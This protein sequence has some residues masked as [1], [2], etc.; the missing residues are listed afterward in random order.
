MVEFGEQIW[1]MPVKSAE[2]CLNKFE[3]RWEQGAFVGVV[4]RTGEIRVMTESGVLRTRSIRRKPATSRWDAA[5]LAKQRGL[6][7]KPNPESDET[8][9]LPAAV[10]IKVDEIKVPPVAPRTVEDMIPRRVYIRSDVELARY[11]H[12]PKCPGCGAALQGAQPRT[13]SEECRA[14][15]ESAMRADPEQATRTDAADARLVEGMREKPG[16]LKSGVPPKRKAETQDPAPDGKG[17][18]VVARPEGPRTGS[19]PRTGRAEPE[20]QPLTGGSS[21]SGMKRGVHEAQLEDQDPRLEAVPEEL[22][23]RS[24][25]RR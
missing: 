17:E 23:P 8:E 15:I 21:G 22:L 19:A 11:G 9:I 12:T 20:E 1:S 2:R 3:G 16:I 24:R 13:H 14:R 5:L 6:P 7:W 10:L 25:T 4:E 18:E